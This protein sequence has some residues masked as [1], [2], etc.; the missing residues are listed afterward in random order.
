M[1]SARQAMVLA[2]AHHR[3]GTFGGAETGADRVDLITVQP[4]APELGPKAP[5]VGAGTEALF[6]IA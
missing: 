3:A 4:A 2:V 5:A 1:V 6:A